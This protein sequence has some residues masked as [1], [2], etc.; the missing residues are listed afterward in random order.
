M[1]AGMDT[2]SLYPLKFSPWLKKKVWGGEKIASFKGIESSRKQIGESWELSGVE[3][4]LSVVSDGPLAGKTILDLVSEYKGRL[5]GDKV[6]AEMGNGF[7]ILVKF[8]D[9]EKD[10]SIQV[11]PNDAMA[12]KLYGKGAKGKAEMWYVI[13]ADKGASILDGLSE[14]ITPEEYEKRVADN[15]ITD[16][17][18]RHEIAPGDVFYI[19]SGRIH[20]IGSGSFVVEIQQTSDYTYRI[21]DYGRLGLHGKPRE[22]HTALAEQA[23]DY[24]VY[25]DYRINCSK[26]KNTENI[27]IRC[28]YFTT[29]LF[30]IDKPYYNDMSSQDS[31]LVV[32]CVEGEADL[33]VVFDNREDRVKIGRGETVLIPA[34]ACGVEFLPSSSDVKLIASRID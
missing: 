2:I 4:H 19:P 1:I 5:V 14:E 30:D 28:D 34:E 3:G 15:T 29:S 13:G 20:A 10:L 25:K 6:Y 23:I 12:E 31:F 33:R 22:L 11:H 9:A 7:P 16:V 27:L 24:K 32:I 26:E 21:Y 17:L 18:A 8:I